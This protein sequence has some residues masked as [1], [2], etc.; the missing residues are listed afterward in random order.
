M[1]ALTEE[2]TNITLGL[3]TKTKS[4]T[5]NFCSTFSDGCSNSS[6]HKKSPSYAAEVSQSPIQRPTSQRSKKTRETVVVPC[7]Q[8]I[9]GL[10]C[11]SSRAFICSFFLSLCYFYPQT[12]PRRDPIK[13]LNKALSCAAWDTKFIFFGINEIKNRTTAQPASFS[14]WTKCLFW[15]D[16]P[17]P[18]F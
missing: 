9:V 17:T 14:F 15:L 18:M 16:M 10:N 8:K 2:L 11:T 6:L 3:M 13:L 7:N 5:L 4:K 1:T 12:D